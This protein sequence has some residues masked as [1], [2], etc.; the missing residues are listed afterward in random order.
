MKPI[1]Q[2]FVYTL[3][4]D[5]AG[6]EIYY[7]FLD[8]G[9]IVRD[10]KTYNLADEI[11]DLI[12][13]HIKVAEKFNPDIKNM[14]VIAAAKCMRSDVNKLE[15]YLLEKPTYYKT[16]TVNLIKN[17]EYYKQIITEFCKQFKPMNKKLQKKA[18]K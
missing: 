17:I 11:C 13:S 12:N 7:I 4:I 6:N 16:E 3:C 9:F 14:T 2:A 8:N 5:D 15:N 18:V 1:G 10:I